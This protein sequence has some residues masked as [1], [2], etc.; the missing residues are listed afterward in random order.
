MCAA[1]P[2]SFPSRLTPACQAQE[3]NLWAVIMEVSKKQKQSSGINKWRA[4]SGDFLFFASLTLLVDLFLLI[5]GQRAWQ[6]ANKRQK[7]SPPIGARW[8]QK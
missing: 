2:L 8:R 3:C 7:L 1:E 4:V 6:H 5:K